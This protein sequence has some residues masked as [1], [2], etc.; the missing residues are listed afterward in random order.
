[1]YAKRP[2][3]GYAKTRLGAD[4][5]EEQAARVYAR[6]LYEYLFDLLRADLASISVDTVELSVAS[7][8]DVLFFS[9]AFPDLSVLPQVA[10]DLGQRM[11]ASFER[12]FEAGAEAV[13][14]TGS[15]IPGLNSQI[16]RAAFD[17]LDTSPVVIGPASD[18]GY[19]LIGMRAPGAALF[20]GIEWGSERVLAQTEAL[21]GAQGLV[22]A[23]LPE[24]YDV[25][26]VEDLVRWR[27]DTLRSDRA[28]PERPGRAKERRDRHTW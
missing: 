21:S 11:A 23:R 10:G 3:P 13:V 7:P 1:V 9:A 28:D 6:L 25:D 17:A 2:L 5:G 18:G 27:Q 4:V 24:L 20:G 8:A 14:L 16:V 12:A 15:D 26:T 22:V 19:Y